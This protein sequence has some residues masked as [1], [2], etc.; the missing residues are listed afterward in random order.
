MAI[1]AYPPRIKIRE[2]LECLTNIITPTDGIGSEQ[3]IALRSMPRQSFTYSIPL[4]NEKQQS[5]FEAVMFG[6][7]KSTWD[8]PIW[9]EKI[10]HTATITAGD[11]VITV[12]TTT[13]DFRNDGYVIIW[14]SLT[15]YEKVLIDTVN[16]GSLTLSAAVVST[17][18]GNKFI[19]PCRTANVV[20]IARRKNDEV[21]FSIAQVTFAVKDNILLSGYVA[22]Q[23]YADDA[24][25]AE[26]L[27]II[28]TGSVIGMQNKEYS[29]DSDSMLQDYNTGD[30]DYF[31]DSEFNLIVQNWTFY[32]NTRAK[33]WD[34]RLFLHSLLGRR[35]TCWMP[36]YR[37][38][39]IQIETI[40]AADTEI[41][42]ENI[43]LAD[44][45]GLNDL[46]THLAF[47][48]TD[49]TILPRKI[50][51][52]SENTAGYDVVTIDSALGLEV[53]SGDCI[54]SFLDLCRQASDVINIDWTETDRNK[55]N[56][57]FMAVVE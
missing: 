10:L 47:I 1:F 26:D 57:I 38:D 37:E 53:E 15:E 45:M 9:V 30:F 42:V 56:Q 44:N 50:E 24:S 16:A 23:E 17:Y 5:R 43:E 41:Q 55:S 34:F 20:G 48:F 21:P 54:I 4:M 13:A 52:I 18:T 29:S 6:N 51:D 7:Q 33:C 36:T 3:R 8:L 40:G 31:S 11:M 49:G 19:M 22:D 25:P 35:G 12:D 39:L 2:S 14:K 27:P 28:I 46:R 32:N